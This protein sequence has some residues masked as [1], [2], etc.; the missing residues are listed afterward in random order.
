MYKKPLSI[1]TAISIG[2]SA[3]I[4]TADAENHLSGIPVSKS[5][6]IEFEAED[7][8][9]QIHSPYAIR[10]D[11]ENASGGKYVYTDPEQGAGYAPNVSKEKSG[12]L[13]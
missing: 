3:W 13:Q 1:L 4:P 2:I 12:E 9:A 10:Y 8:R 11:D 7:S 6:T 5:Q